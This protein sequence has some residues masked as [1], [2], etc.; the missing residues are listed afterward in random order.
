MRIVVSA[1]YLLCFAIP[2]FSSETTA[3]G[4]LPLEAFG[5]LPVISNVKLAPDGKHV[6]MLRNMQGNTVLLS[7]NVKT[8]DS[9]VLATT[10]NQKFKISWYEWANNDVLLIGARFPAKRHGVST[11][12]TRLLKVNIK[13]GSSLE[14][15]FKTRGAYASDDH[16]SQFQDN[17]IS[18][19][20]QDNEHFLLAVDADLPNQPN[21]YKLSLNNNKREKLQHARENIRGWYADRQGRVRIGLGLDEARVFYIHRNLQTGDW[22]TLWE[23][24]LFDAPDIDILG[25][26]KNPDILYIRAIHQDRYAIFKVNLRSESLEKELVYA[27]HRYDIEGRLIYSRKSGEVVGVTHGEADNGRVYWDQSYKNF[28]RAL[29]KVLPNAANIIISMSEDE[30]KY[31]LLSFQDNKPGIFY[32]GDRDQ[33]SLDVLSSQ[34]PLLKA[35]NLAGKRKVQYI[36]RDGLKIEAYLTEPHYRAPDQL[37]PAVIL[38]HGGPMARDYGGFDWLT[39]FLVNRG[40]LVLQPNFRGSSGYGFDF[41]QASVKGWGKEMQHDLQDAAA[42]LISEKLAAPER[43]CLVGASYGGYAALMGLATQGDTFKCAASINGVTDLTMILSDSRRYT[44][45]EVVKKQFGDDRSQLKEVS[46][47]HLADKI[48]APVLLIHGE[49]DRVV[50]VKHSREMAEELQD[51]DKNVR[52][53]ELPKGNHYLE[54][55]ANR[56]TTL[57][58]LETFLSTYL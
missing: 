17:V 20:P 37:I 14:P 34:Y 6:T 58:E 38:P 55:E 8:M 47:L 36:A 31:V 9:N 48:S 22:Q 10:D 18:L 15:A 19:L 11:T 16:Q 39:E 23:Y 29:D 28:Q 13:Q 54:I 32:L 26:D 12:E 27:D 1:L 44:N 35:D 42:W 4:K 45:R 7:L 53:V 57:R 41:E 40:Y 50:P 30:R 24:Q 2:T 56:L 25:F 52:Y 21:V 3:P 33:G 43:V 5:S 51:L 46:P 49:E